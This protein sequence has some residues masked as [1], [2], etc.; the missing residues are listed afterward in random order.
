MSSFIIS[1]G[2]SGVCPLGRPS[3]TT[4]VP[5]WLGEGWWQEAR[6]HAERREPAAGRQQEQVLSS[7]GICFLEGSQ[8]VL[9]SRG[10]SMAAR[11]VAPEE[12]AGPGEP[13]HRGAL[14]FRVTSWRGPGESLPQG[15]S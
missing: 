2:G 4:L 7:G 5:P 14:Q 13:Q 3:A 9:G 10:R 1:Y 11:G 8:T 6:G 15:P 12:A